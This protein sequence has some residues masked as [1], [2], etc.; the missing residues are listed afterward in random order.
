MVSGG[1]SAQG[2]SSIVFSED[3]DGAAS[4]WVSRNPRDIAVAVR[5]GGATTIPPQDIMRVL[6]QD[7]QENGGCR[8]RFVFE[9]GRSNLGTSI[10]FRTRNHAWGPFSLVES[11]KNVVD[12]CAQHRFELERGL[13]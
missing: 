2:Q 4:R 6:R 13:N 12:A 10:A 8:T 3:A 11:R 7:F 5:L 1:A 9:R